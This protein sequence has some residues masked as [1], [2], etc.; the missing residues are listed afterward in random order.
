MN[1]SLPDQY[2]LIQG[3]GGFGNADAATHPANKVIVGKH[4]LVVDSRT[5]DCKCYPNPSKYRIAIGDV[6]KNITSIELRG[7]ILP[8]SAYN[9]HSTNKY[10]DFAV[11]DSVTLINLRFGGN[12]YT[13]VPN[14]HITPP[15]SGVQAEATAVLTDGN[16]T[17]I[18]LD[19]AGSGY[20]PSNPPKITIDPV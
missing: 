1:T 8:K 5:R 18:T 7:V 13:S 12:G 16:V 9:V 10:I 6:Y 15:Q 3:S 17:S 14:V 2:N 19:V 11:G 4:T 20:S